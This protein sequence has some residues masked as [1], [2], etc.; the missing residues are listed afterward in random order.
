MKKIILFS[1]ALAS[2]LWASFGPNHDADI[3]KFMDELR[4]VN[5]K[6]K[7]N[8][9]I[10]DEKNWHVWGKSAGGRPLLYFTCGENNK[11]T[12]LI[13][14]TIH[15]DEITPVYFGLRSVMFV[16]GEPELCRD[17]RIVIAPIVN[18]DGYLVSP[19]TRVNKNGVD[20]NRNFAT[21]DFDAR[22]NMLWAK[23]FKSDKRRNPGAKGGTEVETQFQQWLIDEFKPDKILSVHS[24]LNFF[25]YDGPSVED[26]K[27]IAEEYIRSCNRL[28]DTVKKA[29]GNYRFLRYGFYPGSLGNY[30]G[31][32]RG[33]PTLTLELP[34][35]DA[36][37]A[38]VY[39][40]QFKKGTK[41]L[42][43]YRVQGKDGSI[44]KNAETET[45]SA[46]QTKSR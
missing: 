4:A 10:Y 9:T 3:A 26:I 16:K 34:T 19:P 8:A 43:M 14:S 30:A 22:A 23:N 15:G 24:P 37:R 32:E 46:D 41:Q 1:L 29:S 42:I 25:D 13:L 27:T 38:K 5:K 11:N 44:A 45:A 31:K 6:T 2:N 39:F 12:T 28:R 35:A 7:W 18:P 33:I 17:H 40:E 20:L 36:R 21:K